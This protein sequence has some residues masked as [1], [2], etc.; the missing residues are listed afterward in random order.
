MSMFIYY[1]TLMEYKYITIEF[2]VATKQQ[3]KRLCWNLIIINTC[4]HEENAVKCEQTAVLLL[5]FTS[6]LQFHPT[7]FNSLNTLILYLTV[8]K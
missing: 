7:G 5:L 2:L 4:I 1:N 3:T 6:L 8:T